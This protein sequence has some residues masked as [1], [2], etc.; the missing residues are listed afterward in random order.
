MARRIVVAVLGTTVVLA[1]IVLMALPG[2]GLLTVLVG[3]GIL[4]AEFAFARRWMHYV[5]A[6]SD[7][8]AA[9][10][11]IP[12]SWRWVFPAI[13]LLITVAAMALPLFVAVV[14]TSDGWRLVH[15]PSISYRYSWT[16][17]QALLEQAQLGD[18]TAR[19]LLRKADPAVAN[20]PSASSP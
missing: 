10:A 12:Q 19:A 7:N 11:G 16:S 8:A 2:P 1:G 17:S 6:R 14:K 15:K 4:S 5:K 3:L 20:A 13:A 18:D 9:A